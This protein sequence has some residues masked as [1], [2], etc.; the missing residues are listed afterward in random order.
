MIKNFIKKKMYKLFVAIALGVFLVSPLTAKAE[1]VENE[2]I[3]V[4]NYLTAL[5]NSNF[6]EA[7]NLLRD[8]TVSV[9]EQI[10]L[11][12]NLSRDPNTQIKSFEILDTINYIGDTTELTV[13]I[14]YK[15]GCI[16]QNFV[17]LKKDGDKYSMIRDKNPVVL[18]EGVLI[19]VFTTMAQLLKW[20]LTTDP[21]NGI[22]NKY[23]ATFSSTASY[24]QLN[25]QS[26]GPNTFRIVKY[27]YFDDTEISYA[28]SVGRNVG[29][30]Q[31]VTL[32]LIPGQSFT[33]VQLRIHTNDNIGSTTF[34]E[35][36][37]Y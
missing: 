32:N 28:A 29:N 14:E 18:K 2:K 16:E 22:F 31:V 26:Y 6:K 33:N 27:G 34:G 8:D 17:N 19:P 24:V 37:A 1:I 25:Y 20:N 30:A 21:G 23:T 7:V 13:N 12:S 9:D 10:K 4:A 36:Y 3:I 11:L 5:Q 15:N 35:I